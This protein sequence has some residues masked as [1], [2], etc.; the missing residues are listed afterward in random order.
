MKD[1]WTRYLNWFAALKPRE[2]LIVAAAAVIGIGFLGFSYGIDPALLAEQTVARELGEAR[3]HLQTQTQIESGL[4][5][6]AQD[7]DA[8]LRNELQ[9]LQTAHGAQHERF[10]RI[11]KATIPPEAMIRLLQSLLGRAPKVQL[12]SLKSLAAEPMTLAT[13]AEAE[14]KGEAAGKTP[15]PMYKHGLQI[16]LQ[17]SFTD[18]LGYLQQLESEMPALGWGALELRTVDYPRAELTLTLFT[19]SLES[20]W[21]RI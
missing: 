17:G 3:L 2:R 4:R 15:A 19:L 1:A 21:L 18:L 8:E 7:P 14:R 20:A 10:A 6:S 9:R 16:R 11:E 13:G 12:I 5:L